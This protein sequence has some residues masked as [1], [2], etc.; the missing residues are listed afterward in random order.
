MDTLVIGC[1]NRAVVLCGQF[2]RCLLKWCYLT[3]WIPT[4]KKHRP[5]ALRPGKWGK[6]RYVEVHNR[7]LHYVESGSS[8]QP[9]MLFLHDL[10][11][12]WY[13]WR[14]QV[15][16][17]SG[18]YWTVAVDLPGWGQS[19][20]LA[21]AGSQP[22]TVDHL[23]SYVTGLLDALGKRHCVLVGH[24]FGAL[25]GWH[26]IRQ[27][28]DRVSK[29]VMMSLP[30][31]GVL[32]ELHRCGAIP[33]RVHLKALLLCT[34]GLSTIL[35]GAELAERLFAHFVQPADLEAY[36]YAFSQPGSV[37]QALR[38]FRNTLVHFLQ[39]KYERDSHKVAPSPGLFLV[40]DSLQGV[41]LAHYRNLL[42]HQS[43]DVQ[44]VRRTGW[45]LPQED[46]ETVNRLMR[47]FLNIKVPPV[48][49]VV[50]KELCIDCASAPIPEHRHAR[51]CAQ[52]CDGEEHW[53]MRYKVRLPIHS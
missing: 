26:L 48:I 21:T 23:A 1:W 22:Y 3:C 45:F 51:S 42:H 52:N 43:L 53:E 28:P 9:L 29:Y 15:A 19:D 16:E 30:P 20:E 33:L 47:K 17:F 11:D 14:H 44:L 32:Q 2:W 25:I 13:G 7:Q 18:D 39:Q 24:G 10:S 38:V 34:P 41:P 37:A 50:R 40:G 5:D 31:L 27:H 36:R 6:H 35:A 8:S 46:P 4:V 49:E 12:F